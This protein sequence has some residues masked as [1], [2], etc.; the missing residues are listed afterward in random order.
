LK[1]LGIKSFMVRGKSI[2]ISFLFPYSETRSY[3]K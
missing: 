2:T 1:S 3:K